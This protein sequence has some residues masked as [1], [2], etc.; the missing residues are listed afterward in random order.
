[1]TM[2]PNMESSKL[3][4]ALAST[5]RPHK[6]VPF[7]RKDE[8]DNPIFNIAMVI[9]TNQES[10]GVAAAAEKQARAMLKEHLPSK[11]EQAKGYEQIFNNVAGVETL[12]RVCRDPDD[13]NKKIFPT[14]KSISD[15]L[16]T[17]E[18]SILLNHYF[19]VQI[20]LGPII[21]SMTEVE[22][23]AWINKLAE[24][25]SSSAYF[26]N[27]LSWEALKELPIAMAARLSSLLTDKSS[28]TGQQEKQPLSEPKKRT[29]KL[30][31][32]ESLQESLSSMISSNTTENLTQ[33]LP[34]KEN[35][36]E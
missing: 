33:P 4:A 8:D 9:M 23:D 35:T 17:D 5:V 6:I 7:P 15:V 11:E 32:S 1:M 13:L 2:P 30:K 29:K 10:L 3:F 20:E 31:T 16:T 21:G 26:L 28:A 22:L 18:I 25:G 19:T 34:D 14:P 36:D 27:S 24:G 12:Y